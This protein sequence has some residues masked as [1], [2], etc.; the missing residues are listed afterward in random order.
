[1]VK[2]FLESVGF[3]IDVN[4]VSVLLGFDFASLGILGHFDLED[5]TTILS[6]NV[7]NPVFS[8]TLSSEKNTNLSF[9]SI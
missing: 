9:V 7:R 1:V 2:I 6:C 4:N 3:C 8:N 5:E